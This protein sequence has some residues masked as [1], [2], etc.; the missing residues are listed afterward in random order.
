MLCAAVRVRV[1]ISASWP[2]ISFGSTA[3]Y[4]HTSICEGQKDCFSLDISFSLLK[5]FDKVELAHII[6]L[7]GA[8]PQWFDIKIP[9]DVFTMICLVSIYH[10]AKLL[11]YCPIPCSAQDNPVAYVIYN[12][13]LA[14][15][16]TLLFH[17]SPQITLWQPLV[18]SL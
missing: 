9:Y 16:H 18:C 17:S 1:L 7:S 15:I 10:R 8:Q 5:H 6:L 3:S 2:V 12:W 4:S 11:R 13:K 14:L